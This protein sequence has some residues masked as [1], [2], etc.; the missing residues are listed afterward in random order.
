[1]PTSYI[2]D[3][4]NWINTKVI[5]NSKK[6]VPPF[7]EREIWWCNVGVNVGIEID[8]KGDEY[9]R[10]VL[11]LLKF[12]SNQF[13]GIPLT[14]KIK[15]ENIFYFKFDCQG[16]QSY[17]CLSQLRVFDSKRLQN[18][19]GEE[20]YLLKESLFFGSNIKA[21]TIFAKIITPFQEIVGLRPISRLI[22]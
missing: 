8:G 1:M 6:T 7:R 3:F 14:S 11:I 10:P 19:F 12:N 2:K 9:M 5:V 21:N 18:R 4:I 13:W 22:I 16:K 20:N 15:K 17:L